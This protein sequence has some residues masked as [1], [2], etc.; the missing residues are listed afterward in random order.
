MFLDVEDIFPNWD[1]YQNIHNESGSAF[2]LKYFF[3]KLDVKEVFCILFLLCYFLH[4]FSLGKG[5]KTEYFC[6]GLVKLNI[7]LNASKPKNLETLKAIQLF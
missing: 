4:L 7:K 1:S 6:I 2:L 3:Y 5:L